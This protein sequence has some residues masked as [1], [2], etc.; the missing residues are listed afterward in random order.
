MHHVGVGRI[1]K[2]KEV[3]LI[4]DSGTVIVTDLK[5]GEVLA[6]NKIEPT[7]SYCQK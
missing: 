3:F 4:L 7:R 5:T 2:S 1:H 6:E